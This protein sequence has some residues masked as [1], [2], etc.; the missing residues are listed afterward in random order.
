M[1]VIPPIGWGCGGG[2]RGGGYDFSCVLLLI[3]ERWIFMLNSI[4]F[5]M[6]CVE[7]Q[8]QSSQVALYCK[9]RI[10]TVTV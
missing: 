5:Y 9:V 4:Q 1:M 8:Q 10:P 2:G 7:L 3:S 6:N